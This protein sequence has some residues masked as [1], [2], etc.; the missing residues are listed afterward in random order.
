MS[1]E[2][3]NVNPETFKLL[4]ERI[5]V[6]M[7]EEMRMTASGTLYLPDDSEEHVYA[8]G[9]VLKLGTGRTTKKG[10][11]RVQGVEVGE[12]VAFIKFVKETHT[13][14]SLREV[15][16]PDLIILGPDDILLVGGDELVAEKLND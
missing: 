15:L 9:R 4:G 11:V 8:C 3:H 16:G 6:R 12:K 14:K 2:K 5:L 7:D 1:D 10:V 13:H